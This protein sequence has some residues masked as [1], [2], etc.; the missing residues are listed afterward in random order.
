MVEVKSSGHFTMSNENCTRAV[1]LLLAVSFIPYLSQE[2]VCVLYN[3]TIIRQNYGFISNAAIGI[4]KCVAMNCC[5][6]LCLP[7][8]VASSTSNLKS[9]LFCASKS[10]LENQSGTSAEVGSF[11]LDADHSVINMLQAKIGFNLPC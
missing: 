10:R 8:N 4:L 9:V 6:D 3:Y 2:C 1:N 11:F 5:S 7:G